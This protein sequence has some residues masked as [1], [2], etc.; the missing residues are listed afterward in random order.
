MKIVTIVTQPNAMLMLDC[1]C[2]LENA[3]ESFKLKLFFKYYNRTRVVLS[4]FTGFNA[5]RWLW[6]LHVFT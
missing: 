2:C 1:G 4:I 5:G 6:L 3:P